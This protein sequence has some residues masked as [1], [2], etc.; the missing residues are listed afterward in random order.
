M[1][2]IKVLKLVGTSSPLPTCNT[3]FPAKGSAETCR[4]PGRK[5]ARLLGVKHRKHYV[6]TAGIMNPDDCRKN[7]AFYLSQ[8]MTI[9]PALLSIMGLLCSQR[10]CN[11][12]IRSTET[13][14]S[15]V[16]Q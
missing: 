13:A 5:G 8:L 2:E 11:E 7:L 9:R 12:I 15:N 16:N 1:E 6:N 14:I 3:P 4:D 10:G